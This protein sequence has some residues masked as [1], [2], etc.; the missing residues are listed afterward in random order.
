MRRSRARTR[1]A[2]ERRLP[3]ILSEGWWSHP[4]NAEMQQKMAAPNKV[5]DTRTEL[6]ELIKKRAEIAVSC[7]QTFILF[8]MIILGRSLIE[9]LPVFTLIYKK[10]GRYRSIDVSMTSERLGAKIHTFVWV[11][12]HVFYSTVINTLIYY[13]DYS[14]NEIFLLTFSSIPVI[15]EYVYDVIHKL[16]TVEEIFNFDQ[17][18]IQGVWPF[19]FVRF[20]FWWRWDTEKI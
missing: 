20:H 11:Y 7:H 19:P 18:S 3:M 5:T 12:K 4:G 15:I 16:L 13:S 17:W 9:F 1:A 6:A 14:L 8:V 10:E 2:R